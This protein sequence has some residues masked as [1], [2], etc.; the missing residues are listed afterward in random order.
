MKLYWKTVKWINAK[1]AIKPEA[2]EMITVYWPKTALVGPLWC[3]PLRSRYFL[4]PANFFSKCSSSSLL[5]SA[6]ISAFLASWSSFCS[7]ASCFFDIQM[8]SHSTSVIFPA[9]T[10]SQVESIFLVLQA[11]KSLIFFLQLS[12]C[13]H[14]PG[15]QTDT[16]WCPQSL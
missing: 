15:W 2:T 11:Q 1:S 14:I 5:R 7:S 10:A 4:F 13:G 8:S 16:H 9:F 12:L 6:S 3:I